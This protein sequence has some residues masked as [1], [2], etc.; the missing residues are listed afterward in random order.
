MRL[1]CAVRL[2]AVFVYAVSLRV[3]RVT[4]P[5]ADQ[6]AGGAAGRVP[7][8]PE[9]GHGN[10]GGDSGVGPVAHRVHSADG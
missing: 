2:Y 3:R 5:A 4:G 7:R 9:D 10:H 1:R 8:V 6:S